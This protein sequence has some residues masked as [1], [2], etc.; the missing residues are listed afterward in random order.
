MLKVTAEPRPDRG[1]HPPGARRDGRR[2]FHRRGPGHLRLKRAIRHA[3][4]SDLV[5]GKVAILADTPKGQ[6]GRPSK[7]LTLDQALADHRRP[8]PA[9][10]GTAA[11][12]ET[13]AARRNS[14]TP[15]S[16]SACCAGCQRKPA[17][18]AGPS[19]P[20]RRPGSP[21]ARSAA[22]AVWRW[23]ACTARPRPNGPAAPSACPAAAVQALHAWSRS[24]AASGSRP[25]KM[26]GHRA[27]VHQPL[28][29]RAGRGERPEDVQAGLRRGWRR[30]GWTPRELRTSFVSL[31]SHQGVS[32]RGDRP[33]RRARHHPH[34]R[35][36]LPPRTGV[37]AI[38]WTFP[39]CCFWCPIVKL[40]LVIRWVILPSRRCFRT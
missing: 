9:G 27:G 7:S 10:D 37:P 3:Q 14:C 17:P 26:A 30:E 18:C 35:D 6:H 34:H 5:A 38:S 20:R 4:A 24:Q 39:L 15:T 29:R 1:R 40:A 16:P 22:V 25:A 2:V 33:P 8:D 13:A 31:M 21:T 32:H 19:G 23:S 28:G 36:R 12:P 11:G